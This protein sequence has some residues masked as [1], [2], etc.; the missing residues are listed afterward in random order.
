MYGIFT[1]IWLILYGRLY[2]REMYQSHGP[3]GMIVNLILLCHILH[4]LLVG[5]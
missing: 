4:S 2:S 1:Y 3:Y 5:G